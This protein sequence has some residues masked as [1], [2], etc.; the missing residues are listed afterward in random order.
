M[1]L[2]RFLKRLF[3]L[4]LM[5]QF[6]RTGYLAGDKFIDPNYQPTPNDFVIELNENH[7]QVIKSVE[8]LFEQL[9]YAYF[10]DESNQVELLE[11][12]KSEFGTSNNSKVSLISKSSALRWY[13]IAIT[14]RFNN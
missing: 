11:Q 12:L 6:S 1:N 13:D 14:K 2:L 5:H 9:F 10:M 4:P 7:I 3:S 8:L